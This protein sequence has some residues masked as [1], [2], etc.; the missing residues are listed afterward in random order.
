MYKVRFL[1][2]ESISCLYQEGFNVTLIY[3]FPLTVLKLTGK[4]LKEVISKAAYEALKTKI[5]N[6]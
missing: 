2:H 4:I 1:Q 3:I 5:M 6:H